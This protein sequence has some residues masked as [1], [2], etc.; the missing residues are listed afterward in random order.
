MI[1]KSLGKEGIGT[2]GIGNGV[3]ELVILVGE[4]ETCMDAIPEQGKQGIHGSQMFRQ[5]GYLSQQVSRE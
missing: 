5:L 2:L 3:E 4:Q 1:L